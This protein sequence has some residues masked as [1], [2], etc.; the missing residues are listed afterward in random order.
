MVSGSGGF[1]AT[2]PQHGLPK[3]PVTKGEYTLELDPIVEFGYL[4]VTVDL[5]GRSKTLAIAFQSS[6]GKHTHDHVTVNL[7]TGKL[8]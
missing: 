5:S 1:A 7:S 8:R 3:A 2:Q 6:D 4:K